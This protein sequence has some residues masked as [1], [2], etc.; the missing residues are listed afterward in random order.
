M[1][2]AKKPSWALAVASLLGLTSAIALVVYLIKAPTDT[3]IFDAVKGLLFW[4][5]PGEPAMQAP[6]LINLSQ[7]NTLFAWAGFTALLAVACLVRAIMTRH[8]VAQTQP[9][10]VAVVI[11]LLTLYCLWHEALPMLEF[12]SGAGRH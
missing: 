10:A 12:L 9:R 3:P 2:P 11:S 5:E 4:G 1:N 8:R 6:P 7:L